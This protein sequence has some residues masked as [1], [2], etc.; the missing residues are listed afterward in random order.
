LLSS[1]LMRTLTLAKV[2]P[3]LIPIPKGLDPALQTY[4][5]NLDRFLKALRERTGGGDDL[6][7][8]SDI[9][10]AA[11][12]LFMAHAHDLD[13]IDRF[14]FITG[15]PESKMG[16]DGDFAF[17]S[18]GGASTTIYHKRLGVWTGVV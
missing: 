8:K 9:A 13:D 16:D 7:E 12:P 1:Q 4:L 17:R 15:A 14:H 6:V 2:D 10:L 18:D 11:P 3:F 5:R